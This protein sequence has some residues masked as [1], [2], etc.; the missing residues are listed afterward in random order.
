MFGWLRVRAFRENFAFDGVQLYIYQKYP[1]GTRFRVKNI[2]M[3]Q[4]T[5]TVA[6]TYQDNGL[7][8]IDPTAA[9]ELMDDL[10]QCGVRPTEGTGSAGQAQAM[11][12]HISDLEKVNDKLFGIVDRVT[13]T[14]TA[15]TRLT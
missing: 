13:T 3:E 2:D 9:Q 1:D 5:E 8:Q 6:S 10:W 14:P 11:Q 12:K 15:T 7:I 4:V